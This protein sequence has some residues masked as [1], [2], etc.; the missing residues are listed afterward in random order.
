MEKQVFYSGKGRRW[1]EGGNEGGGKGGGDGGGER[2]RRRPGEGGGG[3]R[4]EAGG[5]G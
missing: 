1:V 3:V 2:G 5:R 4:Q